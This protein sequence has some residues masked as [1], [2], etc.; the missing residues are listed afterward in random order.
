MKAI[1]VSG[2]GGTDKLELVD[3]PEPVPGPGEVAI[4]VEAAGVNYADVMMRRGLYAGAPQ[5]PFVLGLEVA[6]KVT[7][8]GEG[9]TKVAVGQDVI[10]M[11][12]SRGYA[13]R[14]AVPAAV[15]MPRPAAMPAE[16][17]AA[18]PV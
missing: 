2:F 4:A 14:G 9:V 16:A 17:G 12:P 7:A 13:G 3:L 5:P 10:A 18:F 15:V 11:T 6:G 1:Q 8:L